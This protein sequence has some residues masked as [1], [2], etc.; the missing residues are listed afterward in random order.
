MKL[1]ANDSDGEL[2]IFSLTGGLTEKI[3]VCC[4]MFT[5]LKKGG[6]L[7]HRKTQ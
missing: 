3:Q 4:K 6:I 7:I 1:I 2:S 5:L